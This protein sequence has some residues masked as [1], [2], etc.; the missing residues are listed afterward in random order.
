MTKRTPRAVAAA[1]AAAALLA[2]GPLA[3][4]AVAD[5][6]PAAA[7]TARPSTSDPKFKRI[8]L[9]DQF[10]SEGATFGDFNKDGKNDFVAGP[11][12]YEGPDFVKR[13]ELYKP[14]P[15]D[16]KVYSKNFFNFAYDANHDGWVDV[17]VIGFPGE[18]A[19]WYENS[20]GNFD[21]HWQR[22]EAFD[23]VDNESPT[24]G[25][26]TGDGKPELIFHSRGVL[27]WAEPDAKDPN[28]K[29]TFH[30]LSPQNNRY[31]RFT[32][33]YGYGDVN[34]DG[35]LDILEARG[36]W[37]QPKSLE[38]DPMWTFH[39]QQ[40]YTPGHGDGGAQ[41][42]AYDVNGD[43]LADVVTSLQAHGCGLAWFEQKK[44]D[45]GKI[46]FERHMILSDKPNEKTDGLQI[47]QLH[48]VDL[49]DMDGDG[50][51]DIVT[52]KRY[53]AHG[54]TGDINP[55]DPP[56]LYWFKLVRKD[57]KATFEPHPIDNDSGVGTQVVA[58][59]VNGDGLGDVV[60]G[61][62]HGQYV[63]IQEK[64]QVSQ[65]GADAK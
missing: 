60:V 13:H 1:A 36:W 34:G 45:D 16:P 7:A 55:T 24:F 52:G 49:Y 61:N 9:S 53:W 51:K 30:K 46:T 22:H 5:E 48:A 29:W 40:F 3:L 54:P 15:V 37:E 18:A 35:K 11:Y 65:A 4:R 32:H 8:K 25:D 50:L 23:V 20:K 64:K 26:L 12:W 42:Y 59:D 58:G 17:L 44:G 41:M 43:G 31:Q 57:G 10:F 63:F 2:A 56:V 38:G 62:K 14:E 19:L 47:A 33:G 21:R 27:G 6:K 28:A 39:P